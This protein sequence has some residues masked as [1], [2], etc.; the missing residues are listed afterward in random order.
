VLPEQRVELAGHR[1]R[2][3][4]EAA[5]LERHPLA[6]RPRR[7]DVRRVGAEQIEDADRLDLL[8]A[9]DVGNAVDDARRAGHDRDLAP[10]RRR[11]ADRLQPRDEVVA[12]ARAGHVVGLDPTLPAADHAR[13]QAARSR[14]VHPVA[15][16]GLEDGVESRAL[17]LEHAVVARAHLEHCAALVEQGR[18]QARTAPVDR[19]QAAH[20][21]VLI[22]TARSS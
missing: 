7:D 6:V 5:A 17:D 20:R 22:G 15:E 12:A 11:L 14:D 4:H 13:H 8:A 3:A 18:A 1:G 16:L 21:C 2:E 19:D 10:L 9:Q